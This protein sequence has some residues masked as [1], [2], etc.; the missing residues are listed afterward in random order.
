MLKRVL[1]ILLCCVLGTTTLSAQKARL[2]TYN[3]K[4]ASGVDGIKSL[5]RIAA[6]VERYQP[7]VVAL[8]EVDSMTRRCPQDQIRDL[9]E[10]TGYHG[11]F[12]TCVDYFGGGYGNGVLSKERAISVQRIP[13][14]CRKE[15]RGML[16]VE[17][18]N[19]YFASVHLSLVAEDRVTSVEIIRDL[20][21]KLNK[22]VFVAGDLNV[23]PTERAM[24][25]MKA[26]FRF[27]SDPTRF[28]F[29]S[30]DPTVCG[31]HVMCYGAETTVLKQFIDYDNLASD[32]LPLYVDV[33]YKPIKRSKK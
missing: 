31:D 18:K 9:A 10:K 25:D 28:T 20:V 3:I 24:L 5:D 26:F 13:L 16:L 11:Y 4:H 8:Q 15:P 2:M 14:P 12:M 1:S 23:K 21:S 33:K 27:L 30:N 7:D 17:F 29:P 19:Y 32:H 22:P 6:V